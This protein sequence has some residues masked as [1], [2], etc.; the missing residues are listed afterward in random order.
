MK[1]TVQ[2]YRMPTKHIQIE[3]VEDL[4][5]NQIVM[6]NTLTCTNTDVNLP[7]VEE[8]NTLF[9]YYDEKNSSSKPSYNSN[10]LKK[11]ENKIIGFN[12]I[13]DFS[14]IANGDCVE[15]SK[16]METNSVDLIVTDPPYNLG[17]FMHKRNTNL[18]QMREN[19]FA[20]N[21]WDNVEEGVWLQNMDN[22]FKESNRVLRKKGGLVV[23][24]SLMKVESLIKL[25]Q[26]H[27][28]YYKTVGVWYK[29]NPMP[30]N[31]NL[32]FVNSTECWIYFIN[33]GTTGTFNNNGKV[34][35]DFIESSLTPQGEK[36]H[37][38]HPTQKPLKVLNHF[39]NILSNP[40]DTVF[41]PF[42]GSGSTGVSCE[43]LK[44]NF[45]GIELNTEYYDIAEK[46]IKSI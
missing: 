1:A 14:T 26:K 19:Q 32:H 13:T 35:H 6:R 20:Y 5:E 24:M 36:K 43:L 41:D 39:I 2:K 25:A 8:D 33:E 15:Q 18:I 31:M 9:G 17:E 46:R 44:R 37:G 28:F 29:K 12:K 7:V 30:R 42:M 45:I 3:K 38:K 27:H 40:G 4:N 16:K 21:D 23:F 34:I 22:F 11:F 10:N